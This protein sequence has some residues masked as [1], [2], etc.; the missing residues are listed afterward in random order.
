MPLLTCDP[1]TTEPDFV[2]HVQ[3]VLAAEPQEARAEL[4]QLLRDSHPAYVGRNP[5]AI[6]RMR[7]WVMLALERVG[8][9]DSELAFVLD[10]LEKGA[11]A[12]LVAAA[13]RALRTYRKPHAAFVPVIQR[14]IARIRYGDESLTM[15][16]YSGYALS[17][18]AT[19]ATREL[20]AALRWL[21]PCTPRRHTNRGGDSAAPPASSSR[22][23]GPGEKL[24][25]HGVGG[26]VMSAAL[27]TIASVGAAFF[28]KCV[29]CWTAYLSVFGIAALERIPY[30]PWLLPLF[31]ALMLV[32]IASLW[33][34]QHG[35]VAAFALA[36]AGAQVILVLGIGC[37]I[38][39]AAPLGLA[40][41]TA[42][43]LVSVKSRIELQ[44]QRQQASELQ[45]LV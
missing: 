40:L 29:M 10:E 8:V 39:G 4:V 37:Q 7:G 24:P 22:G 28:P 44:R 43:S 15:H 18:P 20:R 38:P 45:L 1:T 25:T 30:A 5:A 6:V 13:A 23:D 36:V 31:I 26:S 33:P 19:T 34:G 41:S 3:S 35:N 27:S 21:K 2:R 32:N 42:G 12:Y 17:A 14:A 16:Q 9:T 11:D